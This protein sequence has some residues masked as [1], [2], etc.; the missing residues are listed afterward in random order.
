MSPPRLC[1]LLGL[2]AHTHTPSLCP[3][4]DQTQDFIHARQAPN[5]LITSLAPES[6]H[7]QD[8]P[9]QNV[10]SLEA[11]FSCSLPLTEGL[12]PCVMISTSSPVPGSHAMPSLSLA[13]LPC[14]S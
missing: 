13:C 5:T 10:Y 9:T 12:K 4:R 6:F 2:Q 3:A 1:V 11:E 14:P 7:S 8:R